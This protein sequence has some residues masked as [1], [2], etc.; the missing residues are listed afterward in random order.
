MTKEEHRQ[1]HLELHQ[2]FDE[3]LADWIGHQPIDS[4][5]GISNTTI[6]ELMR[7]SH[8]QCIEPTNLPD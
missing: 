2:A 4:R 3:L 8:E 5:K 6:A 7:W 1:R